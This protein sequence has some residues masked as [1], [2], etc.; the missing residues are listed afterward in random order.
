MTRKDYNLIAGVFS[1]IAE[2]IDINETVGADL[3]RRLADEFEQDNPRF[4]RARFL[5]ACGVEQ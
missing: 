1:G 4:D 5:A 2:V 3:A